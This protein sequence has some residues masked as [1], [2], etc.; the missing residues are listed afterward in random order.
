MF[1]LESLRMRYNCIFFFALMSMASAFLMYRSSSDHRQFSLSAG[2]GQKKELTTKVPPLPETPC[3]CTSGK[4]Y[5]DCC[6]PYHDG[7][8]YPE[9]PVLLV[10]SRFSALSYSLVPYVMKTTHPS[11]KEFIPEE[12]VSKRKTWTKNLSSFSSEFEFVEL[13]FDQEENDKIPKGDEAFVSFVAKLKK[14][15]T[16]R[17]AEVMKEKSKFVKE[18]GKWLYRDAVV[19]TQI[20]S[21]KGDIVKPQPRAI[22]T[23]KIGVPEGS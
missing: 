18:N 17:P 19:K 8:S 1:K 11:H 9:D 4:T 21:I 6:K 13:N 2:F 7:V 5:G 14:A 23:N 20:K 15:G 12:K 16:S 3:A 22:S 10:R